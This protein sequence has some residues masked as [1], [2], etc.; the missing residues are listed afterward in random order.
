M[1]LKQIVIF[2]FPKYLNHVGEK[3]LI[4]IKVKVYDVEEKMS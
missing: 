3:L 4:A 1:Q 2:N